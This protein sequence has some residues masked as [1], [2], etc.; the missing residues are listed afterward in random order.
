M[1]MNHP[2]KN[3]SLSAYNYGLLQGKA[4]RVLQTSLSETLAP[5]KLTIPEWKL[6][7]QVYD[8]KKIRV[9]DLAKILDVDP[10]LI[11]SLVKDL[12][13]KKF[14]DKNNDTDD[15]RVVYVTPTIETLELIPQLD[16]VV[17]KSVKNLFKDCSP[18]E[19]ITYLQ[20]LQQLVQN[21][22]INTVKKNYVI[23]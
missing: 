12:Q 4:Y 13:L 19:F 8:Y 3:K 15:R 9:A 1:H 20:V 14:V 11:T 23:D 22:K 16:N 5:F 10:P 17:K 7:G 18:A 6:L 21:G 2:E